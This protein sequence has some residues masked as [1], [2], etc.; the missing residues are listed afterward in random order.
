MTTLRAAAATC[1]HYSAARESRLRRAESLMLGPSHAAEHAR[2]RALGRRQACTRTGHLKKGFVAKVRAMSKRAGKRTLATGPPSAV[3][4]WSSRIH[5]D[6]T[7][8]HATLLP[9][10]K[11][12]YFSY[13]PGETG[14][15]AIWDPDTGTSHSVDPSTHENIWCAGQTQLAD[16]RVLIVG[17]NIPK[18]GAEFRGLDSIYIFDPWTE[19]WSFQGRMN[20]GRWYPTSTLLPNGQVVITSGLKRDGSGAI[21]TDVRRVHPLA[22]TRVG[23][24]RSPRSARRAS[25]SIR[26]ST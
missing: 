4:Q 19:T 8:I 25:T 17:G 5:I 12:L 16:G 15:A 6:V 18:T 14:I 2:A 10:G 7:G 13:G 22:Q 26:A 20:E 24:G 3:G 23:S 21:N 9:T 11:V 1:A